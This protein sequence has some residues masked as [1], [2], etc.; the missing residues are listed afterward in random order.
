MASSGTLVT[1]YS[2]AAAKS[3]VP[4]R[5]STRL[6]ADQRMRRAI[7]VGWPATG[8]ASSWGCFAVHPR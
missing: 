5:I 8:L 2:P 6:P 1:A 3:A 7:I 4:I